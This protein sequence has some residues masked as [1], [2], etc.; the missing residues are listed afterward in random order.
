MS[1]IYWDSDARHGA[2]GF[3]RQTDG[4][5]AIL[6]QSDWEL[7]GI[8]IMFGGILGELVD[9]GCQHLGTDGTVK[10]SH[11]GADVGDFISAS[12]RY[13]DGCDGQSVEDPGFFW[14][15]E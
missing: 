10:C 6:V 1:G 8:A 13:L 12:M 15:D 5:R 3:I 9:N 2:Y 14:G 4:G 11:C 7:P